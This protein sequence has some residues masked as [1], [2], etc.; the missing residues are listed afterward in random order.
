M[1]PGI[2]TEF[3]NYLSIVVSISLQRAEFHPQRAHTDVCN[4]ALGF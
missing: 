3:N 1:H 2:W 4:T